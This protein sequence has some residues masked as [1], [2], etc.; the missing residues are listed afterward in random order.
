MTTVRDITVVIACKNRDENLSLCLSSIIQAE[1]RPNGVYVVDFGSSVSLKAKYKRYF[2]YVVVIPVHNRTGT[3][4]KAR[5]VNI[6]LTKV[7]TKYVCFTDTDQVFGPNT[8]G[9][10]SSM[11]SLYPNP[12]MYSS[13]YFIKSAIPEGVTPENVSVKYPELLELAKLE[14]TPYGDGCL[15]VVKTKYAKA[16]G[17]Y[18]EQFLGWGPEDSDFR[19]MAKANKLKFV[20]I[21]KR[22]TMIHLPHAKSG[23]YYS[24]E[25]YEK[26]LLLYKNRRKAHAARANSGI[27][28]GSVP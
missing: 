24:K 4:H 3:F 15:H 11:C 17:G 16:I 21:T 19:R 26:N 6:G 9:V 5:A 25:L 18:E 28:W 1:P 12:F 13:T 27:A 22:V 14:S 8:F 10:I 2:P 20:D 23:Q 7:K